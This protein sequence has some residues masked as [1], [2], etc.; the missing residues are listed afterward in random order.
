MRTKYSGLLVAIMLVVGACGATNEPAS[1][2][3]SVSPSTPPAASASGQPPASSEPSA[4]PVMKDTSLGV[5]VAASGLTEPTAL[6]FVGANDFFVTEKST[7]QVHHVVDGQVGE[8]V[9][10]LAV[11]SF[12]ERGLLGIALH[13]EFAANGFVY[14]YWTESAKGESGEGMFG[15][16]TD[17]AK[18]LPALGN[19]VDRFIWDGTKLAWDRNL[20]TAPEQYARY[21]HVGPHPRQPRRRTARLRQGRQAVHHHR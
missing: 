13:P 3:A 9:L 19:R 6:A 2:P 11:N 21:R 8:P 4:A 20:V 16:D 5:E 18:T 17:D 15:A 14:L 12:D 10:D 1:S 7:G